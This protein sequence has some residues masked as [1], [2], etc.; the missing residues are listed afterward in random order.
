MAN[1]DPGLHAS[2]GYQ[3]AP[4]WLFLFASALLA[5]AGWLAGEVLATAPDGA[6]I[7][8]AECWG[9]ESSPLVSVHDASNSVIWLVCVLLCGVLAWL[10]TTEHLWRTTMVFPVQVAEWAAFVGLSGASHLAERVALYHAVPWLSAVLLLLCAAAGVLAISHTVAVTP[11]LRSW[12]RSVR[13]SEEAAR[14]RRQ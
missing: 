5:G 14:G 9:E 3:R 4:L 2:G 12:L 10:V 7:A 13:L 6:Y 1:D 8:R 11:R